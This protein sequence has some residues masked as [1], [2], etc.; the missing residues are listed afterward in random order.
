[1]TS[2]IIRKLAEQ[3][4]GG[5]TTEVQVVY[6]LAGIRKLIERD[7]RDQIY[8][9]LKFHCDWALHSRMNRAAAR[10]ILLQ[11]DEAHLR[12]QGEIELHDLPTGLRREIDRISQMKSFEAELSQ[13]L[14]DYELPQLTRA[15]ND[16]W[17]Y[18]LY[19]YTKVVEDIPLV[20]VRDNRP[21]IHPQNISHVTVHFEE[22]RETLKY[23]DMEEVLFKVTWTVHD[24]DGRSGDIYVINSFALRPEK[25]LGVDT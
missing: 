19:L 6:V 7:Q 23:E 14:S 24:N 21:V 8:P 22:A 16:G 2:E 11:F 20:A 18:F 4:D 17:V 10:K 9:N 3:I 1:M 5:I 25:D 13:F 15:R 12:L